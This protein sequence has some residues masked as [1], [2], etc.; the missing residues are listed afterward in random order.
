MERFATMLRMGDGTGWHF[1]NGAWED[2]DDEG[3][4]VPE[5]IRRRP[6][7]G[8]Q[9]HHY[10]FRLDRDYGDFRARFGFSLTP[11]SDAGLI[12]HAAAP[13]DFFVLHFP[14]CGQAD[15]AQ[16]F[17]AVISR[18]QGDGWLRIVRMELLRRVSSTT[19]PNHEVDVQ[20]I[21]NR[22][23][24]RIDGRGVF[25]VTDPVLAGSGRA[26]LFLFNNAS[27]SHVSL[28]GETRAP[29]VWADA[30]PRTSW[31]NPVTGTEPGT[32]QRP[33]QL[34]RTGD[35]LLLSFTTQKPAYS[36]NTSE[37]VARSADNGRT[38]SPPERVTTHEAE[39]WDGW[40]L[41]HRWPDGVARMLISSETGARMA[42]GGT[43]GKLWHAPRP[44]SMPSAPDGMK[45][46][47]PGPLLNLADGSVLAF[48]YGGHD[49]TIPGSSIFAWGSCHCQAF[50]ARTTDHGATWSEWVNI[51]G[52]R[53]WSGKPAG[54]SLDLTEI[55]GAEVAPGRIV[56]LIRPIYSPWM[57]ETWSEDGG[58]SWTPCVR[59]PFPG[60]ATS[61][62]LRT[63][64]GVLLVAHRLPGCTVHASYDDGVS[65]DAGTQID[66]A[67]WVMG[68]M[69]EVEPDRVLY[70]YWDSFESSMRA[71][72]IRVTPRGLIPEKR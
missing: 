5:A 21:G 41:I 43:D 35:D 71:Q 60:Y 22:L 36:G 34:I 10:A 25:D 51:D 46:V 24:A 32:W 8:L 38:W 68:G 2:A 19:S 64:S 15:R 26:G 56:A 17:W 9:G 65:W 49:S 28:E 29:R 30:K 72:F 45:R 70:V 44:I 47:H 39:A 37:F 61:N 69:I 52:T 54:G 14:D 63:A 67:I 48:G 53:D 23:F 20:L 62:M 18:M 33:G 12:F 4:R 31:F 3:I 11:H 27:L 1:E 13:D 55:C 57:W 16:H 59:G 42:E 6:G 40:G 66:S 50:A 58:A 7:E